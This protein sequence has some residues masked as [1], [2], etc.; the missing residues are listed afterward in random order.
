MS[1]QLVN[2]QCPSCT[3]PLHFDG[4]T[5][6][7]KCDYCGSLFTVAEIEQYYAQQVEAAAEVVDQDPDWDLTMFGNWSAEEAAHLRAYNCPSCSAQLICDENTAATSCPYC[8]N[9]TVVPGQFTGM[10]KPDFVLPFK[11]DKRQAIA[12]L[13]KHYEGKRFLPN[14]FAANNHIQEITGIYVPFWLF[15]ASVRGRALF[16][17]TRVST[18]RSGNEE[19]TSTDHYRV[20]RGGEISFENVPVDGSSKMPDAHMDAIEP[21][22]FRDLKG[23]TTAYLPGFLADRYDVSAEESS[24]RANER[25]RNSTFDALAAT[26]NGYSTVTRRQSNAQISAG[27]VRYVL[28]PVWT[29]ST[30][31]NGKN[32]LFAMNGQTGKLIG[33]L[34]I[35]YGKYW[36]SFF[37]IAGVLMLIFYV[38]FFWIM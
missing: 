34:P 9:P 7:L 3:G 26:V 38:L 32:F 2:Y 28:M 10:L 11:L 35:D 27:Q 19:I 13:R 20:T 37:G 4:A 8:G 31:W 21:F 6:K 29:L 25:I 33:D 23:F 30:K 24:L 16:D 15:D 18:S 12:A 5:G 22:D 1:E 14:S 17:A 36:Q